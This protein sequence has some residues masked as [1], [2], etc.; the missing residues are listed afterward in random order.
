MLS[1]IRTLYSGITVAPLLDKFAIFENGKQ[2]CRLKS[3][4]KFL[5]CKLL[6]RHKEGNSMF[7]TVKN[8]LS[9]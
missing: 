5:I 1:N 9:I 4:N 7:V 2:F 3:K 8:R 6:Y